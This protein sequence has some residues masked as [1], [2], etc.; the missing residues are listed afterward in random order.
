LFNSRFLELADVAMTEHFRH[1]GWPYRELVK[2]G[3]DPS[4]V[5]AA[6]TFQSPARF[7]DL[8]TVETRCDRV[9]RSSFDLQFVVLCEGR[10]IAQMTLVY[11]NVD[12]VAG[13]SVPLPQ[14]VAAA[15]RNSP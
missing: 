4:V 11:V 2:A 1:I 7:E 6:L 15:L 3:V 10:A 8:L 12:A 5:S 9:G 14:A 13:T